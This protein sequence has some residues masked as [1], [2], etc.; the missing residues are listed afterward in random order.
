VPPAVPVSGIVLS[1]IKLPLREAG[2]RRILVEFAQ[3]PRWQ[4]SVLLRAR[5]MGGCSEEKVR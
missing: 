1:E 2:A 5:R 3:S 4:A